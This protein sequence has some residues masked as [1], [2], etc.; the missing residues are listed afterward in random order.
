V[1]DFHVVFC[2]F[3]RFVLVHSKELKVCCCWDI[4]WNVVN[5]NLLSSF[6]KFYSFINLVKLCVWPCL[7]KNYLLIYL[8][9][10]CFSAD[11]AD[12][13]RQTVPRHLPN[14]IAVRGTS[15]S[16]LL[17]DDRLDYCKSEW[18]RVVCGRCRPLV[19]LEVGCGS[20][21]VSA[22]IA[23]VLGPCAAVYL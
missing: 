1:R 14:F 20:G 17:A 4:L 9:E 15:G 7:I 8:L 6:L 19:C 18:W 3:E 10:G 21:A 23:N 12:L 2:L 11:R 5:K 22:F 13:R 16:L